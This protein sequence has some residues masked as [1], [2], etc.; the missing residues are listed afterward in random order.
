MVKQDLAP[1]VKLDK[2]S[3][4]FAACHGKRRQKNNKQ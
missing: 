2:I 1:R 3:S 4:L